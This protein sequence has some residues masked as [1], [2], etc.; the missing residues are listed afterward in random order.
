MELLHFQ[1]PWSVSKLG[2]W[3]KK[4]ENSPYLEVPSLIFSRDFPPLMQFKMII[5][6][7]PL[8]ETDKFLIRNIWVWNLW[9]VAKTIYAVTRQ[10]CQLTISKHF[11]S[12]WGFERF[13]NFSILW[14]YCWK[15]ILTRQLSLTSFRVSIIEGN[16]RTA[17]QC[18]DCVQVA[19]AE[20]SW[21]H[22]LPAAG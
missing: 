16:F 7:I 19:V 1:F 20:Q 9:N 21:A 3:H 14:I 5:F 22:L 17:W 4:Q 15:F 10:G 11:T 13:L 2:N 8:E 12:W 6:Q 18:R